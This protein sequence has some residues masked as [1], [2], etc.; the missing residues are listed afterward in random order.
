VRIEREAKARRDLAEAI[1]RGLDWAE[2]RIS[3]SD[4]LRYGSGDD[5]VDRALTYVVR[6][7]PAAL[8]TLGAVRQGVPRREL[9]DRVAAAAEA[10]RRSRRPGAG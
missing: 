2:T 9:V 10:R 1:E 4:V 6:G 3:D 7:V 5:R 8:R